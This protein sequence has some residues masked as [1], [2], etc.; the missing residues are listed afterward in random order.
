MENHRGTVRFS[1][2][3]RFFVAF[4]VKKKGKK[5]KKRRKKEKKIK[6]ER[7]KKS[8][9][10]KRHANRIGLELTTPRGTMR[11]EGEE[12]GDY[13]KKEKKKQRG[14]ERERECVR[15]EKKDQKRRIGFSRGEIGFVPARRSRARTLATRALRLSLRMRAPAR[16][17]ERA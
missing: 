8:A 14:R 17:T 16:A 1:G 3:P 6:R 2:H 5:E 10:D 13:G 15:K 12:G 4:G 7:E 11:G 9:F